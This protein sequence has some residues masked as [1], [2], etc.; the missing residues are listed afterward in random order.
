MP[1]VFQGISVSVN[2]AG[3]FPQALRASS[4]FAKGEPS[5]VVPGCG[6]VKNFAFDVDFYEHLWYNTVYRNG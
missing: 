2:A 1:G 4:P 3:G 6:L 5:G